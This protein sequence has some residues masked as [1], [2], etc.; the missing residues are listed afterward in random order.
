MRSIFIVVATLLAICGSAFAQ[1]LTTG[2]I[3][4]VVKDEGTGEPVTGAVVTATSGGS[5]PQ[6]AITDFD[7]SYKITELPPGTYTV[8][9][10]YDK[11]KLERRGIEVGIDKVTNVFAALK[12]NETIVVKA[13]P[14]QIRTTDTAHRTT[15]GRPELDSL[16]LPGPTF[17]SAI[18]GIGGAQNDGYGV[19]F[20]SST[21][22]ENRYIVD[23]I[24]ITGLTF[25]DVGTPVLNEFIEELEVVSGGYNA[26]YGRAT[27]GIVNLVT[28][29][30]TNTLRGSI[31]G[32]LT[33]GFLTAES[34]RT[35]VNASSIDVTAQRDYT[36]HFGFELGGP[37]K[38]DHA[39]FYVGASPQYS[40]TTYVRTTKRQTDCKKI[41]EGG[42]LS[43]CQPEN[44]DGVPDIDP[45]TGF[46]L[47]DDLDHEDRPAVSRSYSLVGKLTL[48]PTARDRAQVSIIAIPSSS[49]SPGLY[50]LPQTGRRT[51]GLTTDT[52][53]RWTSKFNDSKTEIEGVLS[54][55][56]SSSDGG[57][58]DPTLDDDPRQLLY[59]GNLGTW[60]KLGG[61]TMATGAGCSD[62]GNGDPYKLITNCPVNVPYSIGGPGALTRDRED[63]RAARVS[64]VERFHHHEIKA[65]L[66]YEDNNKEA[67]RLLSGGRAIDNFL[68]S[69]VTV[70][71]WVE[72][73]APGDMDPRFD[74]TCT[75]P[76]TSGDI[77]GGPRSFR[78]AY[79]SGHAGDPGTI[80]GGQTIDWAAYLRDSWQI[81]PNLTLNAGVR[82]EEQLMRYASHLR[83]TTD[84]LTG[85]HLGST[86]M[87]LRG[88]VAPRIGIIYDP[89]SQGRSKIY[90]HWG[91]FYES[92]PMDIN[93]RSFGGEVNLR[94]VYDSKDCGPTDPKIGGPD[95]TKCMGKPTSETL[96]GSSG[97]LVAPGI[98]A[99]YIDELIVG[100][101]VSV[102]PDTVFGIHVQHRRMGRAIEDVSTD[103]ANTYIIAN[104]GEWSR[105]DE[106]A[107]EQRI[108]ATTDK[109]LR[110]RLEHE[111][112]LFRGIRTFDKPVRDY[113]ALEVA[114]R[115]KLP[116]GLYL[117]GSYTYS[118]TD[119]NYPGSVSYDNGQIDPNIS[120]QYD[121]IELLANRRGRLPQDRPHSVKLDAYRA[122]EVKGGILTVGSRVR[123]ISGIPTNALAGHYLYGADESF[124]LPRGV[125]GR[126]DFEHA[127][128]LH[129]GYR[130]KLSQTTSAELYV[131][132]FNLYNRQAA[133]DVDNTYAPYYRLSSAGNPGE[134]EN[135]N[136][137]SGGT[138]DDLIWAKTVDQN[139]TETGRPLGRNPNFHHTSSRYA[140]ASA[141]VGFRVT[142]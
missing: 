90:G 92:V 111:L 24:D 83:G 139:G 56:R 43:T 102:I 14:V 45:N 66:D 71:R 32:V 21:S 114:I 48:A 57:S 40:R 138:Y 95:G 113:D 9:F 58:L 18:G 69:S 97:V 13:R 100:A 130:K 6:G 107:L 81:R 137:I 103:G 15:M 61:E 135:A 64:L 27:G 39:W 118:R 5:A 44:A 85:N 60:S 36:G 74:Q 120:S 124:L 37:I 136:P 10:T 87:T 86:A 19:A 93:D 101:E 52:A 22:L 142:F 46:F 26:E 7:G 125:L 128:D 77:T 119:G 112:T 123:A 98:K 122:F 63:R 79:L 91:R 76:S 16:P 11:A 38:K 33:P 133:F 109:Q 67:A 126:S 82:Y 49:E 35:P 47:T 55:H 78:C 96:I 59:G 1:S 121:L 65:G 140:P 62:G 30:G 25:G 70:N 51:T 106:Q 117:D 127:I 104:P 88:N 31:F 28:R 89:T 141:Q 68:G 72:L 8:T 108:A 115:R 2:A 12:A 42:G 134:Q 34:Q 41:L 84:P 23:G 132:V 53:A 73:A 29:S 4:G 75:T 110:N 54:W 20:S 116:G 99:E 50:G 80:V 17:T 129:V 105:D 3:Q 131:D 94:Q